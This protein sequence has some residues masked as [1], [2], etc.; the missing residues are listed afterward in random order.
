MK[1]ILLEDEEPDEGQLCLVYRPYLWSASKITRGEY[2][3]V[4]YDVDGRVWSYCDCD[5]DVLE[6]ELVTHWMPMPDPPE[7]VDKYVFD[8][9]GE[10][11]PVP[12]TQ[13]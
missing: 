1:W 2:G 9:F 12:S 6:P 4:P 3:K 7:G 10:Q 8:R 5:L 13:L 11:I